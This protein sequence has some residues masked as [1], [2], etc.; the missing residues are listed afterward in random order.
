MDRRGQS[1]R[2]RPAQSHPPAAVQP[3][4]SAAASHS[5]PRAPLHAERLVCERWISSRKISLLHFRWNNHDSGEMEPTDQ[6][7]RAVNGSITHSGYITQNGWRPLSCAEHEEGRTNQARERDVIGM[8]GTNSLQVSAG[9]L[10]NGDNKSQSLTSF[11]LREGGA[12]RCHPAVLY[13]INYVT[14]MLY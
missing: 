1:Q 5:W 7:G 11:I 3:G 8:A 9:S 4:G 6:R 13:L 14:D 10:K 12:R 2:D